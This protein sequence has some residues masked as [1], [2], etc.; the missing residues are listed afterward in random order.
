[1]RRHQ[2]TASTAGGS[3]VVAMRKLAEQ[4]A[5]PAQRE[6]IAELMRDGIAKIMHKDDDHTANNVWRMLETLAAAAPAWESDFL[7][8]VARSIYWSGPPT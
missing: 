5:D 8:N 2:P 7:E 1:V 6:E 4:I 3:A